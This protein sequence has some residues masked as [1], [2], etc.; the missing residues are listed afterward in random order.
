LTCYE[1]VELSFDGK[2]HGKGVDK[3]NATLR[4]KQEVPDRS[5]RFGIREDEFLIFNLWISLS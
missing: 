4:S 3:S 2:E 1:H 5:G